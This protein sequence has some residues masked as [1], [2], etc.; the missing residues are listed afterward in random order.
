MVH[1]LVVMIARTLCLLLVAGLVAGA[2]LGTGPE[3]KAAATPS[4]SAQ[5][6]GTAT[7]TAEPSRLC[8]AGH[9][10]ALLA[11][12]APM[13]PPSLSAG[14]VQPPRSLTAS[15]KCDNAPPVQP[16]RTMA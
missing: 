2:M 1:E 8:T 6:Q 11:G 10:C 16:P 5:V 13:R 3:S 9:A 15:P 4:L 7:E 14:T 12:A